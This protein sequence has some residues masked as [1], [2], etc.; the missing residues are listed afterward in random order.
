MPGIL[1]AITGVGL[2]TILY[3][4]LAALQQLS[5]ARVLG[6]T[7]AADAFFLAQVLPVLLAG[8]LFNALSTSTIYLAGQNG[9]TADSKPGQAAGQLL[10]V[11]G[12]G[13]VAAVVLYAGAGGL[14]VGMLGASSSSPEL[15][16]QAVALQQILLPVLVFQALG[17]VLTGILLANR[18]FLAP[19]LSMCLM[20]ASGITGLWLTW[21][22]TANRL[23]LGLAAGAALQA[24]VL[25][26]VLRRELF[27]ARPVMTGG[28][29]RALWM[30]ALPAMGCNAISTLLL[31]SDRSFAA[32]FGAGSVASMSYVYSLITLPTQILVNSVVGISMRHWVDNRDNPPAFSEAIN[33]ALALLSFA[34]VPVTL[35][36]VFGAGTFTS[37]VLGTTKFTPEQIAS[38]A[39][40]LA[41][42]TPAI[43]GFAAKDVLT[44]A[45]LA[46]G[47]P[48][49]ALGIGL[50]GVAVAAI[51]KWLLAPW[52]GITAAAVATSA[53][54]LFS[55]AFLA[56]R[57]P[58]GCRY[59]QYS[60][61]MILAAVPALA[62]GIGVAGLLNTRV[63][64]HGY[65]WV[66]ATA[67]LITYMGCW[68][69]LGGFA[70]GAQVLRGRW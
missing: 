43:I 2:V 37:L 57:S 5:I 33:K 6:A 45:A 27:L 62:I 23:A 4:S 61:E 21:D 17:G 3:K 12:T 16:S 15:V 14:L 60:R 9:G 11:L 39:A 41:A 1:R 29:F 63:D 26:A 36:M 64:S 38:T 51:V 22:G 10:Q 49:V 52:L 68:Y 58:I 69:R 44:A 25:M 24:L 13:L 32:A 50:G 66:P 31:V 42:Y 53:G 7:A 59:W 20:Y 48:L 28:Q 65:A 67:A 34:L 30:Q 8:L 18:R 35:G 40:L 47:R 19:P 55:V 54:L 70:T 56:L 46:Q